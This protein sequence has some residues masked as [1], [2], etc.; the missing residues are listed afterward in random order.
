MSGLFRSVYIIC[1]LFVK[2]ETYRW[3][4]CCLIRNVE[5]ERTDCQV[6]LRE[7]SGPGVQYHQ[8][9]EAQW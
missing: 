2:F 9:Q 6:G 7:P 3:G 4:W 5:D 8:Q 1:K